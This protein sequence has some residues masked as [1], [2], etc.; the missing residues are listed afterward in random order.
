[1]S[2]RA[3]ALKTPETQRQ[4][5]A[6]MFAVNILSGNASLQDYTNVQDDSFNKLLIKT[7]KQIRKSNPQYHGVIVPGLD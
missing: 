3:E 1:M 7:V 4:E 2:L 5:A 6:I